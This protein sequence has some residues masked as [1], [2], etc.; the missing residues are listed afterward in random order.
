MWKVTEGEVCVNSARSLRERQ[1]FP[2]V[3]CDTSVGK[4][5]IFDVMC[6]TCIYSESQIKVE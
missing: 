3:P 6:V 4:Y 5:D 2:V 1:S